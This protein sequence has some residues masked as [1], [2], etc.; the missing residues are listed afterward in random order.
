MTDSSSSEA[1]EEV[2]AAEGK[3]VAGRSRMKRSQTAKSQR[4]L[5]SRRSHQS[6]KSRYSRKSSQYSGGSDEERDHPFDR[7]FSKKVNS[8]IQQSNIQ[9]VKLNLNEFKQI[10]FEPYFPWIVIDFV[11]YLTGYRIAE[12]DRIQREKQTIESRKKDYTEQF[13]AAKLQ[14]PTIKDE[15][16]QERYYQLTKT[17][18]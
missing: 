5:R 13:K 18:A 9:M 12:Y 15:Q 10:D 14:D 17:P 11:E 2:N 4:S 6:R 8:K 1:D 7:I 3:S 16:F